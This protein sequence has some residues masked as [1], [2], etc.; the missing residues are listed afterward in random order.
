MSDVEERTTY[1]LVDGENIDATLGTTIL[2]R[3]PQS[4]ERPRWDR[5]L[6][7]TERSWQQPVQGLFFL[8]ANSELPLPF[9]QALLAIGYRVVQYNAGSQFERYMWGGIGNAG[10]GSMGSGT[11]KSTG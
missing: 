11:G 9:V 7:F 10:E 6:E 5:L 1:V 3:R 2:Q 4:D 8:A